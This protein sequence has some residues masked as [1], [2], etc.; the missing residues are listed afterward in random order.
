MLG[1]HAS[2]F[3]STMGTGGNFMNAGFGGQPSEIIENREV[4][5]NYYDNENRGGG[6]ADAG[7]GGGD[8][9]SNTSDDGYG[10]PPHDDF[11]DT[12]NDTSSSVDNSD[13][14]TPPQDD[15]NDGSL[16]DSGSDSGSFSDD[17]GSNDNL[18]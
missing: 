14:S 16:F 6:N 12:N 1:N 8:A 18:V 11:T 7:G 9:I 17:S 4:V 3:G 2:G 5:N 13:Y 15:P 10:T